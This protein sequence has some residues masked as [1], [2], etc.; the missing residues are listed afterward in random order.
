MLSDRLSEREFQGQVLELAR[1]YGWMAYHTYDS[2]KSAPGFPDLILAKDG[3]VLALELKS[4]TGRLTE[5]QQEWLDALT[6]ARIVFAGEVRPDDLDSIAQMM[7]GSVSVR[8][9]LGR[10]K[11]NMF[12]CVQCWNWHPEK[13]FYDGSELKTRCQKCRARMSGDAG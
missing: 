8:R 13:M 10:S 2:R 4:A 6:D 5:A 11:E 12:E 9:W 7:S 3:N 1:L